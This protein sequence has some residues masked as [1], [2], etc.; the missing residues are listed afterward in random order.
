MFRDT[1][2]LEQMFYPHKTNGLD[3]QEGTMMQTTKP[4]VWNKKSPYTAM[5]KSYQAAAD[6]LRRRRRMLLA[7]LNDLQQNKN[8]TADSAKKQKDLEGR[9]AL[10]YTEYLEAADAMRAISVYAQKEAE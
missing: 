10:L 7:E 1:M 3:K 2:E 5:L 8:C 9:I 6:R 4:T